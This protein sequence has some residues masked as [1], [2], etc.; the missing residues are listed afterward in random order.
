VRRHPLR[1]E[2]QYWAMVF[3]LGMYTTATLRLSEALEL[4]FLLIIPRFFLYVALG[5][6]LLTFAGLIGHLAGRRS[7]RREQEKAAALSP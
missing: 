5:A 1:Y 3:P 7:A 2:A 6:W 4:P